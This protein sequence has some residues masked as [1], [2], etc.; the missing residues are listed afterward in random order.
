M[1]NRVLVASLVTV[2][3]VFSVAAV[4][5]P[6]AWRMVSLL[7]A[8]LAVVVLFWTWAVRRPKASRV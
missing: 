1:S 7:A 6:N 2:W 3:V 5:V 8:L 4:L